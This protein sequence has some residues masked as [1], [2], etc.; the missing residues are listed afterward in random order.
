MWTTQEWDRLPYV[1]GGLL[2]GNWD[3]RIREASGGRKSLDGAYDPGYDV[4]S[5]GNTGLIKDVRPGGPAAPGVRA[6]P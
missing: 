2:A 4:E 1:R 3:A 6:R 5:L